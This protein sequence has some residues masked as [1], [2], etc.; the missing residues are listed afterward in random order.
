MINISKKDFTALINKRYKGLS[1]Q[2]KIIDLFFYDGKK[3]IKYMEYMKKLNMI[4]EWQIN[5]QL[6]FCFYLFDF[7]ND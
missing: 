3:Q 6:G 7:N 4:L 5:D 1:L 2:K